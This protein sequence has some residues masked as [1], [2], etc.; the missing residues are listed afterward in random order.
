VLS[1]K[2]TWEKGLDIGER[3][4]KPYYLSKDNHGG[5]IRNIKQRTDIRKYPFVNR[6]I[7]PWNLLPADASE[8]F[9]CKPSKFRK[10]VRQV[11]NP[12]K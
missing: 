5:K 6:T 10:R 4:Q 2:R 9:S 3:L 7:Q 1:S 11:V 12:V 8:T